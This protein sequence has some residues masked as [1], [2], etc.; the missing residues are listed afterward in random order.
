[1][2]ANPDK[3]HPLLSIKIPKVV[4]IDCIQTTSS[5]AETVLGITIDSELN[6][7]LKYLPYVTR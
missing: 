5:T 7:E 2:K 6:F 3:C 1:M 4:S